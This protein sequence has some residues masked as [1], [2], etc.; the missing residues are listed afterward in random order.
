LGFECGEAGFVIRTAEDAGGIAD[1]VSQE[2]A[3]GREGAGELGDEDLGDTKGNG[4][5]AGGGGA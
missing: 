1:V 3:Q 4:Y 5:F 2:Q